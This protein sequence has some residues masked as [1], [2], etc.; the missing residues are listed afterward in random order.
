[1]SERPVRNMAASVRARLLALAQGRGEQLE[2]VLVRFAIERFLYRLSRSPHAQR[3]VL[4]GAMMFQVWEGE[5]PRTTR[6]LD[7]LGLGEQ[8][9]EEIAKVVRE[10]CQTEVEDDGLR[11]DLESLRAEPIREGTTHVGL[12]VRWRALLGSAVIPLQV[13]V[14][15]GD[16]V[17]ESE[18]IDYPT[19]LELP[20]PRLEAYSKVAMV[21]EKTQA[22]LD[23]GLANS[24]MKDYFDLSYLA[25]ASAFDGVRLGAA[26]EATFRRRRTELPTGEVVGLSSRFAE[27]AEKKAQWSGFLLRMELPQTPL[28]EVVEQVGRLVMPVLGALAS[29]RAFDASWPPG[30]PWRSGSQEKT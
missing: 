17:A 4:K 12:R 20:A 30:G 9:V 6:D 16:A 18:V 5:L 28:A 29:G 22:M 25:G 8:T 27:D 14:G 10:V 11:F 21:A 26:L 1:M 15:I 3:F 19:L 2:R 7:L 13:D 24:R 23:L